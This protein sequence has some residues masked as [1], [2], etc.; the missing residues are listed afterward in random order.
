MHYPCNTQP[1]L[2]RGVQVR[3]ISCGA[4]AFSTMAAPITQA[5]VATLGHL[6]RALVQLYSQLFT[7]MPL[8]FQTLIHPLTLAVTTAFPSAV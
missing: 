7:L 6:A 8:L 5:S 1:Q 3:L 2:V 4:E